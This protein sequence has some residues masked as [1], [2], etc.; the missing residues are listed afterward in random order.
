MVVQWEQD[1]GGPDWHLQVSGGITADVKRVGG[2][3]YVLICGMPQ[4]PCYR[5]PTPGE[6]M[7]KAT[8]LLRDHL[9]SALAKIS[10]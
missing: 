6:A 7:T 5:Y 9:Q 4:P 3:W 2:E 1:F 8:N 10:N